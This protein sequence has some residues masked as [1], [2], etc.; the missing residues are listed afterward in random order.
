MREGEGRRHGSCCVSPT[1]LKTNRAQH[2]HCE[3]DQWSHAFNHVCVS[4]CADSV[5]TCRLLWTR[6]QVV[7]RQCWQTLHQAH[8]W[9]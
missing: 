6:L 8:L 7:S 9:R 4:M 5:C 1:S 2:S 3:Q